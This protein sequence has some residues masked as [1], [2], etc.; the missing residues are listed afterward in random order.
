MMQKINVVFN[1]KSVKIKK[2]NTNLS[3]N[4]RLNIEFVRLVLCLDV[5]PTGKSD[6]LWDYWEVTMSQF[7]RWDNLAVIVGESI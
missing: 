4:L 1:S 3:I 6:T 7:S 2:T 5:K